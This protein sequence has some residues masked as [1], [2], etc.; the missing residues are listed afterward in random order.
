MAPDIPTGMNK[1]ESWLVEMNSICFKP[2]KQNYGDRFWEKKLTE[3]KSK[4]QVTILNDFVIW[5]I[6]KVFFEFVKTLPLCY[7]LVWR[8]QGMCNLRPQP[9]IKRVV[10]EVKGDVN[11]DH[12]GS[13]QEF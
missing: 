4:M 11:P 5:T 3:F 9:G 7:V 12:Q 10:P 2:L 8:P 13:P 1:Y 6:I